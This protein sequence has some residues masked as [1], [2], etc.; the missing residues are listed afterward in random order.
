MEKAKVYYTDFRAKLGEGLPTKLKRLMKKAGISEIDMENK[1]VAIKMQSEF[2]KTSKDI[3]KTK[4][5]LEA[6]PGNVKKEKRLKTDEEY[7]NSLQKKLS[8]IEELKQQYGKEIPLACCLFVKYGHQI[9]YL[10][11]SSNY[12]HRVFRGPYA[13]QWKMIQEAMDEGYD[14]YNFYG[15]SGYFNKGEE[16][17]GVFRWY[18]HLPTLPAIGRF[19]AEGIPCHRGIRYCVGSALEAR[20]PAR[21]FSDVFQRRCGDGGIHIPPF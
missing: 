3:E 2:D 12:E 18:A 13:I 7:Y 9:V 20:H 5:F 8:H 11:G 19:S 21:P 15:I 14:L 10:V 1:F 16:G 17:F 4:A 6:N